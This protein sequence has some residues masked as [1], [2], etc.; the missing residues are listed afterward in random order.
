MLDDDFF[1][2][3]ILSITSFP[4][5]FFT[6]I[7][8]FSCFWYILKRVLT[9]LFLKNSCSPNNWVVAF[10]KERSD[11]CSK[12]NKSNKSKKRYT[13]FVKKEKVRFGVKKFFFFFRS[14]LVL[15]VEPWQQL[16]QL[17]LVRQ[18]PSLPD[19]LCVA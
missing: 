15:L 14:Q 10:F 5:F 19:Q 18:P 7:L 8:F 13:I 6:L 9:I 16:Q 11:F 1:K 12:S 17:P 2:N 4:S 3:V